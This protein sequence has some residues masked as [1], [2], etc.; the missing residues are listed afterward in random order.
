MTAVEAF[1]M[2]DADNDGWISTDEVDVALK[3]LKLG[4]SS[5][6]I[7]EIVHRADLNKDGFLD[8]RACCCAYHAYAHVNI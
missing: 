6:E 1:N 5:D 4:L 8:Y 7:A 2:F 3:K